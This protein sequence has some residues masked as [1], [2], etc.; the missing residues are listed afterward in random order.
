ML[1]TGRIDMS[2]SSYWVLRTHGVTL[3]VLYAILVEN[4]GIIIA[5][6]LSLVLTVALFRFALRHRNNFHG[7]YYSD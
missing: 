2:S 7:G 5:Q 6:V 4:I 1:K 3:W